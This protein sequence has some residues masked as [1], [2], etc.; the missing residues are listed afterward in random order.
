[1]LTREVPFRGMEGIQVAWFVVTKEEVY[2]NEKIIIFKCN[3]RW[4]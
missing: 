1:M 2:N 4:L 3:T